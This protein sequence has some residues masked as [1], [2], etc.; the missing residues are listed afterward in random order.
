MMTE[1]INK[2]KEKT[3]LFEKIKEKE[4]DFISFIHKRLG[5]V[6]R[7]QIHEMYQ[8][9]SEACQKFSLDPAEYLKKLMT[10]P[11]DSPL[12]AHLVRGITIGETYFFRDKNQMNMLRE[13]ILPELILKKRKENNLSLRIWSAGCSSGE[14][15]YTVVMMLDDLLPD[16]TKWTLNLIGTDINTELLQKAIRGQYTEWSMRSITDY[17]KNNYFSRQKSIYLLSDRVKNKV[18]FFYLNLN[19]NG[20]PSIFNNTNAQ[21][22]I[23]CRNVLI[24][25]D[26]VSASQIMK[27]MHASLIP[28]GYLLLGA[29]DPI[30]QGEIN[31]IYLYQP[32]AFLK[33]PEIP[34]QSVE[35]KPLV[36]HKEEIIKTQRKSDFLHQEKVLPSIIIK[37]ESDEFQKK[38]D[39]LLH[40]LRWQEILECIHQREEAGERS[41][42]LN[43]IK[44]TAYANLGQL[45]Q[46]MRFCKESLAEDPTNKFTYLTYSLILSELNQLNE[47]EEA[48]RKVLFLD[49]QFVVGHFQL[50]LLLLRKKSV[51]K[52]LKC[53]RNALNL[54]RKEEEGKIVPGSQGIS[55]GHF[56]EILK[57][58]IDVYESR[59]H[60]DER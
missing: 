28:G 34:I 41:A 47:S 9:I 19:E 27:K 31:S 6:V 35:R 17:H 25:F 58:E 3:L 29:S 2:N 37:K 50:G 7:H 54:S 43:S 15:I 48:L 26:L 21:D 56:S 10:C 16:I 57:H 44:A 1:I 22:L 51:E 20:Y 55:Y 52:G 53:L 14:E 42:N 39:E 38:M 11:S 46:A 32:G 45:D 12:L 33:K 36:I 59:N 5:I 13:V 24:Y 49:H 23:I 18:N 30:D 8:S 4:N 60:S 40:E